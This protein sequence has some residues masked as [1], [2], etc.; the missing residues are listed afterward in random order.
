MKLEGKKVLV[1]GADRM[2]EAF[3]KSFDLLVSIARPFNTF[4]LRQSARAINHKTRI[5]QDPKRIPTARSE[6]RRLYGS[7][8]KITRVYL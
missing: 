6:V 1:T 3:Y 7:N 4:G 5:I 2:S 8:S